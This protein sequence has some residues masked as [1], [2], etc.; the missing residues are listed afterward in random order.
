MLKYHVIKGRV[1][2]TDAVAKGS[3]S[4]LQGGDVMFGIRDGRMTVNGAN[5]IDTN[6]NASNGIVHVIDTVILPE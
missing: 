3:A 1:S 2:A 5:V 6:I 4:T